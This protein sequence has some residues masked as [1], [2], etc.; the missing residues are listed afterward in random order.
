MTASCT[1]P[2]ITSAN[3]ESR[4]TAII[5]GPVPEEE[6]RSG[7]TRIRW[8]C[9]PASRWIGIKVSVRPIPSNM[10]GPKTR[11][12]SLIFQ[13]QS[14]PRLRCELVFDALS[15]Q[16]R[17]KICGASQVREGPCLYF[18]R[19]AKAMPLSVSTV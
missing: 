18:G 11:T 3:T 4:N 10:M 1:S 14:A 5:E 2:K 12:A 7:G 9:R 6:V 17:S 16:V 8:G 19:S 13:G 15:I